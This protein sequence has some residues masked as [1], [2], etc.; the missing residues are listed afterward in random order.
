MLS[1]SIIALRARYDFVFG[2]E[3]VEK[4][5]EENPLHPFALPVK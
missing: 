4:I 5:I 2:Y 1:Q 3:E